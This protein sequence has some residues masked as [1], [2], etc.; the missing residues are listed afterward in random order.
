MRRL[1]IRTK[2]TLWFLLS[3]V[4]IT[5]LLFGLLYAMTAAVLHRKLESDLP[6]PWSRSAC[7]L[8]TST[9]A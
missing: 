6:W 4:L 9:A 3:T 1:K 7:R 2:M 8:S 5:G